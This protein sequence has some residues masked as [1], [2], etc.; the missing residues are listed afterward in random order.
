[1]D[2]LTQA[3]LDAQN[4]NVDNFVGEASDGGDDADAEYSAMQALVSQATA[5]VSDGEIDPDLA[6]A[7]DLS[8]GI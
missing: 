6:G 1:M 3:D 7:A 4:I 2:Q 8:G 5:E